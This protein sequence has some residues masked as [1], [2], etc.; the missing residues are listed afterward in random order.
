M[1]LEKIG[2]PLPSL[3]RRTELSHLYLI[4][5]VLNKARMIFFFSKLPIPIP[6]Q[7]KKKITDLNRGIKIPFLFLK[8]LC[9]LK[10]HDSMLETWVSSIE[11]RRVK[12][13]AN[14]QT[15]IW[16]GLQITGASA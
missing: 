4:P 10:V 1:A 14:Y 13:C 16:H 15:P 3:K 6:L 7:R 5:T 12:F 8:T 11:K 2:M 9:G